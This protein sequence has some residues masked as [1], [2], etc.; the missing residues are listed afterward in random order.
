MNNKN[1]WKNNLREENEKFKSVTLQLKDKLE[2]SIITNAKLLYSNRV[3]ISASLN[4]R[5]KKQIV[6]ALTKAHT[7]DEAKTI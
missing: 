3:L 5:Q 2:E 1:S 6:E 4:E 7:V